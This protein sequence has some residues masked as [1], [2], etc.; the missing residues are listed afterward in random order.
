MKKENLLLFVK[1]IGR[2]YQDPTGNI[3]QFQNI[4]NTLSSKSLL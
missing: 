1:K 4:N 3:I 2:I